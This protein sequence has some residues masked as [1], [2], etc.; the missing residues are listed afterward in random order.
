[1]TW[2][3]KSS[4]FFYSKLLVTPRG[5]HQRRPTLRPRMG[6]GPSMSIVVKTLNL[7]TFV[8]KDEEE[9]RLCE[10]EEGR[11]CV[12]PLPKDGMVVYRCVWMMFA[13]D[14]ARSWLLISVIYNKS[15]Y[16]C[17]H[18]KIL[19]CCIFAVPLWM[20]VWRRQGFTK[21]CSHS[22][23]CFSPMLMAPVRER[24]TCVKP[25]LGQQEWTVPYAHDN[26]NLHI[27]CILCGA[28]LKS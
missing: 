23:P 25:V 3:S 15:T 20:H 9:P 2:P 12:C 4:F 10:A 28:F 5:E 24:A 13:C 27:K 8:T 26:Y 17:L 18:P 1:M 22:P 16:I 14:F 21:Q 6:L 19:G 11:S 7:A